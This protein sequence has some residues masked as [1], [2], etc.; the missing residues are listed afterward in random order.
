MT[1]F[2]LSLNLTADG[3]KNPAQAQAFV[4]SV[5][6]T[7]EQGGGS[8]EAS[9]WTEGNPDM[10]AI[11]DAPAEQVQN[12]ETALERG[13]IVTV[14]T[15]S[16]LSADEFVAHV[17]GRAGEVNADA[18]KTHAD[19][20]AKTH[21]ED[22]A[23]THAEGEAKTHAEGQAKTHAEGEAKTHAEGEAKT[24]AE[25]QAKTHAEGQAKTHAQ[26]GD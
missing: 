18:A 20:T 26:G 5:L 7:F 10:I 9:R 24:H 15:V 13:G 19:G 16:G 3:V 25:G 2:V 4:S 21:A 17:Q 23:K 22:E 11:V 14:G 8:L 1:K 12:L 6:E